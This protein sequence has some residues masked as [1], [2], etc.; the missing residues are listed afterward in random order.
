M[1]EVVERGACAGLPARALE[2]ARLIEIRVRRL[3]RSLMVGEYGSV[4]K[5]SGMEFHEIREYVPGDDVRAIDWKTTAKLGTPYVRVCIEEKDLPVVFLVD[6]SGSMDYGSGES[7][8]REE[9]AVLTALLGLAALRW[10]NPVGLIAFSDRVEFMVRPRRGRKVLTEMTA[11]LLGAEPMGRG[12]DVGAGI[13]AVLRVGWKR[14][15][16][17]IVS[18]FDAGDFS[19]PLRSLAARCTV[20]PV[21]LSDEREEKI[22]DVG[23]VKF[24]DTETGETAVFDA[25]DE[26]FRDH[27]ASCFRRLKARR[28]AIFRNCGVEW[29]DL[30]VSTPSLRPLREFFGKRV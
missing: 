24:V 23:F 16:V 22:P 1:T 21:V 14:G 11:R 27:V 20:V 7:T 3:V 28:E 4:F 8:K 30:C 19:L 25:S 17:F 2:E 5:G 10:N 26:G 29:I 13:D 18:D 9:A 12:S 6:V 15:L